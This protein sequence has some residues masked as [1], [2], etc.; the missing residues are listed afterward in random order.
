[1]D[2]PRDRGRSTTHFSSDWQRAVVVTHATGDVVSYTWDGEWKVATRHEFASRDQVAIELSTC[3]FLCDPYL[4][5]V[6]LSKLRDEEEAQLVA[7]FY[8]PVS[9]ELVEEHDL[10]ERF[11][12]GSNEDV[13]VSY[14]PAQNLIYVSPNRG[15]ISPGFPSSSVVAG[16]VAPWNIVGYTVSF[17]DGTA[18]HNNVRVIGATPTGIACFDTTTRSV[19]V[20]DF[21]NGNPTYAVTPSMGTASGPPRSEEIM[22]MHVTNPDRGDITIYDYVRKVAYVFIGDTYRKHNAVDSS[23]SPCPEKLE[24]DVTFTW[25]KKEPHL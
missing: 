14:S 22:P 15:V 11:I 6:R 1:M 13:F 5:V 12:C 10:T 4:V 24:P 17:V 21:S 25:S 20:R 9:G 8:D 3:A 18:D 19:Y 23:S 2:E 16:D 7:L